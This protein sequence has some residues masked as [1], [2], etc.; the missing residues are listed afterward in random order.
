MIAVEIVVGSEFRPEEDVLGEFGVSIEGVSDAVSI[1]HRSGKSESHVGLLQIEAAI[2]VGSVEIGDSR[3]EGDTS[4]LVGDVL[5]DEYSECTLWGVGLNSMDLCFE[6]PLSC[7]DGKLQ[8]CAVF[9]MCVEGI[10]VLVVFFAYME[11][12]ACRD[13]QVLPLV[14]GREVGVVSMGRKIDLIACPWEVS[15]VGIGLEGEPTRGVP[16]GSQIDSAFVL[17]VGSFAE[18]LCV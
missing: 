3:V 13:A 7:V 18:R 14:N 17:Y 15:I 1:E 8:S 4:E 9:S 16:F 5:A 11:P 10:L 12:V 2:V 6:V